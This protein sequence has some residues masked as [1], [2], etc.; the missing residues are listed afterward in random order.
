MYFN[1]IVKNPLFLINELAN[2]GM[3][4]TSHKGGGETKMKTKLKLLLL[5]SLLLSIALLSSPVMAGSKNQNDENGKSYERGT[6]RTTGTN[7]LGCRPPENAPNYWVYLPTDLL[8]P[9]PLLHEW[10]GGPCCPSNIL[11]GIGNDYPL[12]NQCCNGPDYLPDGPPFFGATSGEE[13]PGNWCLCF[14]VRGY[15]D[16]LLQ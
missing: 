9:I 10:E 13:A 12:P 8:P 6:G 5:T 2:T 16:I 7:M 15:P 11:S 1:T 3:S 14:H 4:R